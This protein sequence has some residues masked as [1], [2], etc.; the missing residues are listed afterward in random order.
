MT[1]GRPIIVTFC[2]SFLTRSKTGLQ[3]CG[4][5]ELAGS[6]RSRFLRLAS[7][8]RVWP[9]RTRVPVRL[10]GLPPL[11]TPVAMRQKRSERVI[12]PLP[13]V[14]HQLSKLLRPT[15]HA[16]QHPP[17]AESGLADGHDGDDRERTAPSPPA[18]TRSTGSHASPVT[19]ERV[20]SAASVDTSDSDH[21]TTASTSDESAA[22]PSYLRHV[23]SGRRCFSVTPL[24]SVP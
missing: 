22:V 18:Q 3:Y 12:V 2:D 7:R 21:L 20:S 14:L 1:P 11:E 15:L 5:G 6:P 23:M 8:D 9:T 16:R 4:T 13:T 17:T 24:R 19:S 10:R